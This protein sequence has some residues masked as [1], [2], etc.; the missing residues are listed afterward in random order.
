MEKCKACG[1]EIK[2]TVTTREIAP[3]YY[4]NQKL[5]VCAKC[6]VKAAHGELVVKE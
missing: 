6:G 3:G 1:G 5:L 4:F 2:E